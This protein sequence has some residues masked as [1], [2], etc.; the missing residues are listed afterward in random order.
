MVCLTVAERKKS[1]DWINESCLEPTSERRVEWIQDKVA[2]AGL[3]Q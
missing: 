3:S 2:Q 1:I